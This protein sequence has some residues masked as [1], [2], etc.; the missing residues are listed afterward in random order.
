M[1]IKRQLI[2]TIKKSSRKF[3]KQYLLP[4][5]KQ[6]I[7][8]LRTFFVN[9]SKRSTV[10][11]GFVLPTVAMV[12]LVV[13]LLTT[14]ILFRS[15]ERA[16]NAS[17]VRV[18]EVV[19]NAATPA[20]DRARAK[21]DA[22]FEDPTL[23][24][25]T[26]SDSSLYEALKRDRYKLGD[27]IRLK[28]GFDIDNSGTIS[29]PTSSTT[30][31]NDE[32]LKTAWKYA[33]DTD[34]NG[35]KDTITLYGI[36]FRSPTRDATTGN[37]NRKRNSLEARTPPMDNA[38]TNQACS[39][40]TGF[41]SL[42]GN[43]SWYRLNSGNL[44]KSFFVYVVNVPL[45]NIGSLSTT[46]YETYK[47]NQSVVALELQQDR[48]RIPLPNNA[49]WFEND[50]EIMIGSTNLALNGRIHTNSNLL[51][52]EVGGNIT[53]RQ[54]SSK[55]SCFY[56]QDN[57]QII[58]GGN[59][60]NGSFTLASGGGV[61]VDLF[62]GFGNNI[63]TADIDGTNRSTGASNSAGNVEYNDAAF[64]QR[65]AA[66]KTDAIAL[67]TSCNSA[68]TTSA[69]KTAITGSTYPD[70]IKNNA[71]NKILST[72]DLETA[73]NILYDEMEIYLRNRTRRVP[74]AEVSDV[75]G[76]GAT[77][78]YTSSN[79]GDTTIG[80]TLAPPAS[81]RE[82]INSSNQ[83]TGATTIAMTPAQ[84]RATHPNLQ[85]REGVQ[86]ELG[87]RIL[88]GNNLPA[89]WVL[90]NKYVGSE[91]NQPI[92]SSG[93][94]AQAWTRNGTEPQ[95]QRWRN[96]QIQALADLGLS[97]RNGFWEENAAKNP[98]NDLD[99]VGG[100]RI[101]TGAGLYVDGPGSTVN[102]TTTASTGPYYPR[103]LNS[104]LPVPTAAPGVTPGTDDVLVWPDTMPMSSPGSNLPGDLLM[105]ATAVY[106]YKVDS[107]NDQEPIACVSSYYDPSDENSNKNK[108]GLTVPPVPPA[109]TP[110]TVNLPWN[111][112]TGGKS[113]N[114]I[115]YSYPTGGRGTFYNTNKARL[116]RQAN[117]KFPNGR[118]ANDS[119][120]Q[121]LVNLKATNAGSLPTT[122]P[123]TGLQL[124]DYSAIDT[125]LCAISIL[126][127]E[128]SFVATPT[129][130]PKHG[131]I[132]ESAFLDAREVK[133]L[134]TPI[135]S[136]TYNVDIEQRQP[137]EVR[138]TDIDLSTT[139]SIGI[140]NTAITADEYLLP[141]SGIVFATRD[142]GLRD[143]SVGYTEGNVREESNSKL[144]SPTDFRLDPRRRP[145]GI[146]LVNGGTLART[147]TNVHN[148]K[149]KGLIL[150]TNLPAYIRGNFNLHSTSTT[151]G[152]EEFTETEATT[153]FYNRST[154]NESFACRKNRP[155][156]TLPAGDTT[157]DF[158][159]PAT[160]IAD[161]M[162]LLSTNFVDGQ[163]RY[164]DYDLNNN[165]GIAL[166]DGLNPTALPATLDDRRRNRLKNGFWE[167]NYATSSLWT[168]GGNTPRTE[169]IHSYVVNGVTPIQRRVNSH[170]LYVMEMCRKL[171]I[172]ECGPNDWVVGFDINGDGDVGDIASFDVNGDGTVNSS[173]LERDIKAYQ[174]GRATLAAAPS[175]T[176]I[177]S[178][179]WNTTY[180]TGSKTIRQRLGAGDTSNDRLALQGSVDQDR[181]FPRRV[182][183]A[184]D[185]N[186]N[187]VESS[188]GIYKPM[189]VS[190]PLDTTGNTYSNNGCTYGT[191]YGSTSTSTRALWFRTTTS[192][193]NPGDITTISY[194]SDKPLFYYPPIDG[195]DAGTDPDLDGQPL[196]VPVLQI[197][198]ANNVPPNLRADATTIANSDDSRG[199][200]LQQGANT[201]FNATFVIGNSPSRTDELSAGLQNF[202]RFLENW[203]SRTARISGSF[204]QLKRSGYATAPISPMFS[205]R[206][207]TVA[208]A[209]D[210][211]SLF[212]YA[213]DI[214]PTKNSDGLLPTYSPPTNR[215]WGFDVGL[216]SEQP[217]LFAQRFTSPPTS[218]PNE[219]FREVG[220]DDAW[221]K[222][223]LCAGEL[224][225]G[226]TYVNAVP[227]QYRPSDCKSIPND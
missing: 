153:N 17:N 31:E 59:V 14:A 207:S 41:A 2:K 200:W 18:N 154:R 69:F 11:A 210:N 106:H 42:V 111:S 143:E 91:A 182:A 162:T 128:N 23:P 212:D 192:T 195:P 37:F 193:T 5:K 16:K 156:C 125:A 89:K 70:D 133:Q 95:T 32:T 105:R 56:N 148:S 40:A 173:D 155:G 20:I 189:G 139:N 82:P 213:L 194:A 202:V 219:F 158:W 57:G 39:N 136:T 208:T 101:V 190:C 30:L 171:L 138:V 123:S 134:S 28:M 19:L 170:P 80:D 94:T 60:K 35:L 214:Y 181:R 21:M 120:R 29:Q 142:D 172:S 113:N 33:V 126:S 165:T 90:N 77:T 203:D 211:L 79:L 187:L 180:G 145:N 36:F 205:S 130:Q 26:P 51:V 141:Y 178:T 74:F 1:P 144:L 78:G 84:L 118:W 186:N 216:L 64:N 151:S 34:N 159:R 104:F 102:A 58:V 54:V 114:G 44:G 127:A 3:R 85:R 81:W 117:L 67:C 140:T 66:M 191:D 112:A 150:V 177:T 65:I 38:T 62:R 6:I 110:T 73:K 13:V 61:T 224:G 55:T 98:I 164:G 53:V 204:I 183:F 25:G 72:D 22:L 68:T 197:H 45:T 119:L 46:E 24:R 47:G 188:T 174:L 137:L 163:R 48:S 10:N 9:R 225:T 76:V 63:T 83:L 221:V 75:T 222:T 201:T 100:V 87:D 92:F 209:A 4:I 15:F 166:E 109:T 146:R 115:V 27:E 116:E 88:V 12:A 43:S 129:N 215:T 223:L 71:N 198:D 121:A 131:A 176:S 50:L 132:S 149:E 135:T 122:V 179:W 49:V 185:N 169:A 107:G 152:I 160:I 199:S 168:G 196:L 124:S 167:N 93:T 147:S 184:R 52:A 206:Q 217:D 108:T 7:W 157:G 226:T 96:T 227:G 175:S 86:T 103:T 99:S 220:R 161:S 218:R 97:D 8:L